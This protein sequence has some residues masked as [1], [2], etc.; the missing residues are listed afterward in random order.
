MKVNKKEKAEVIQQYEK[1][2]DYE[3]RVRMEIRK[4][5]VL[6]MPAYIDNSVKRTAYY[7]NKKKRECMD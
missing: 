2:E 6:H 4:R 5:V 7:I 1:Y 3:Q